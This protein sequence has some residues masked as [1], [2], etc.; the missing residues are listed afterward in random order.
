MKT[1]HARRPCGLFGLVVGL[2]I[3]MSVSAEA[4]P[5]TDGLA[6][7]ARVRVRAPETV[8]FTT[9]AVVDSIGTDSLFLR[10]LREPPA[11][12]SVARLAVPMADI[13]RLDVSVGRASRWSHARTGAFWGLGIYALAA[14]ALIVHESTTCHVDCFGEGMAWLG[15]AAGVPTA[16]AVGSAVGFVL[17]VERWRAL[18]PPRR[19]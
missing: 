9:T 14:G 19:D 8:P 6:V 12:R 1:R 15:I 13:T 16:A 2:T 11:L 4:Q 7:G 3:A 10:D 5:R 17:P 18:I